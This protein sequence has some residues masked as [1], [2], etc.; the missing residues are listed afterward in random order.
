MTT[1]FHRFSSFSSRQVQKSNTKACLTVSL[2]ELRNN[3]CLHGQA[4]GVFSLCT[5]K[6]SVGWAMLKIFWKLRMCLHKSFKIATLHHAIRCL[7]PSS[8]SHIVLCGLCPL[9]TCAACPVLSCPAT[10]AS[11]LVVLSSVL[12]RLS[13]VLAQMALAPEEVQGPRT[14]SLL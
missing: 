10:Q 3:V 4:K 1:K 6:N 7:K 8:L 2:P 11:V 14:L 13:C 12:S 5:L 9:S